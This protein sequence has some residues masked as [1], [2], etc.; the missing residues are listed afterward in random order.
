MYKTV[1]FDLDDTLTEN[2]ENIKQ[3][4]KSVLRYKNEEYSEEKFDKFHKINLG[5]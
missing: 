3:A 5:R 2:L 1:I 4:F